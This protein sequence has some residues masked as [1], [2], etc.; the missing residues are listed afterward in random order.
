MNQ[1]P[2][3]K[4]NDK[5]IQNQL[6]CLVQLEEPSSYIFDTF[7]SHEYNE[8][9][10]FITGGGTHSINFK[11]YDI[12]DYS[13]HLLATNDLHWVERSQTSNGFAIMYKDQLLH[14]LQVLNQTINYFELF[15]ASNVINL[16]EN[17]RES[18]GFLFD[19]IISSKQHSEY[20][21][22]L[23]ATLITKLATTHFD[24]LNNKR[25]FDPLIHQVIILIEEHYKKQLTVNEY[26]KILNLESRTL[27]NRISKT[28]GKTIKELQNDRLLKE[29]KRL[30]CIS[31]MNIGEIGFELGF[32]D[33]AYFSNWFKK[34][35]GIIP[36]EYKL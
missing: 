23:V 35:T 27:Q 5:D 29:A 4:F 11:F 19:E 6:V 3:Y 8:I 30:I 15:G 22:Q 34:H 33:T 13:I 7:H 1:F 10:V 12:N 28:S 31:G 20:L 32:N 25:L 9:L 2:I 21:L 16:D 18:F 26:A 14:K 36:S 24:F 17:N